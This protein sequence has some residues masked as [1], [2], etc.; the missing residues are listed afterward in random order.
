LAANGGSALTLTAIYTETAV[1]ILNGPYD[2]DA[3]LGG[4]SAAGFAKYM[5]L[6]SKCFVL[7]A[8]VRV[9]GVLTGAGYN[10]P[11]LSAVLV[12]YTITT[13]TSSLTSTTNAIQAGLCSYQLVNVN[14]DRFE[15]NL[16]IDVA[17]F[18]D[19]PDLLDDNQFFCT[20]SA[21][22][23]QVIAGHLWYLCPAAAGATTINYIVEVEMDCVFTDPIP[24]T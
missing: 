11:P 21:N 9:K 22:P 2:P 6:Y 10:G 16:S 5:A 7:G 17:K 24:F 13:N 8:K 19:K 12:G 18:V 20:S 3:A 23:A 1:Q 15:F 4:L 14:P